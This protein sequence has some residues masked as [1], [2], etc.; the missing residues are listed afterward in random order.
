MLNS[1]E[2]SPSPSSADD[3]SFWINYKENSTLILPQQDT[4]LADS[5]KEEKVI[6][7]DKDVLSLR[8]WS[9]IR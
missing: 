5:G 9:Q 4:F 3:V 2:N 7:E 8:F 1:A 6:E